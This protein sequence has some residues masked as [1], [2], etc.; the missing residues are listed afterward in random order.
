MEEGENHEAKGGLTYHIMASFAEV[1]IEILYKPKL[2][3]HDDIHIIRREN[4]GSAH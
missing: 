2:K 3:T 4:I 1:A